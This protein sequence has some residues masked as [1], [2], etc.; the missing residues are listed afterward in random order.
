MQYSL[1]HIPSGLPLHPVQPATRALPGTSCPMGPA[2]PP[3]QLTG[4]FW[5]ET[6]HVLLALGGSE[7]AGLTQAEQP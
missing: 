5:D 1:T 3:P 2:Q 4:S 7:V 6:G